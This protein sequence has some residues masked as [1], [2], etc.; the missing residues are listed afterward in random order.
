MLEKRQGFTLIELLVVIAIIGLLSTM[1]VVSLS[2]ARRKSRDAKRIADVKQIQMALEMYYDDQNGYPV[3]TNLVLGG[4]GASKICDN[5]FTDSGCTQI[6][7]GV[8]PAAPTPFD[9]PCS[10]GQNSYIYTGTSS[11]YTISFCLGGK[12]GT[13]DSGVHTASE[14]GI[15]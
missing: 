11:T 4:T 7:M 2:S 12:T 5:G 13:L 9:S 6:Y 8:V 14:I 15:E 1:A 10:A 3:R